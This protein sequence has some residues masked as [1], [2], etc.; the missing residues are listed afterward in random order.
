[1]QEDIISFW[2]IAFDLSSSGCKFRKSLCSIN[3]RQEFKAMFLVFCFV[4]YMQVQKQTSHQSQ[5]ELELPVVPRASGNVVKKRR[6][7][8]SGGKKTSTNCS[9]KYFRFDLQIWPYT[10]H[11]PTDFHTQKHAKAAMGRSRRYCSFCGSR[12]S[13]P[14]P[15]C[16]DLVYW[17][18]LWQQSTAAASMERTTE[19]SIIRRV[20]TPPSTQHTKT[21][22]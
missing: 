21:H 15:C 6:N 13:D 14:T 20:M 2:Q 3:S 16:S 4:H 17:L 7:W 8:S 9:I 18:F 22:S 10:Y 11:T 19:S 12:W 1:M 5:L